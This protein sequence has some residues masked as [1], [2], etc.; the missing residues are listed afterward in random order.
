MSV[1]SNPTSERIRRLQAEVRH[2]I[3]KAQE[4]VREARKQGFAVG[5]ITGGCIVIALD[6]FM[7]L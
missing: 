5:C 2:E 1:Y 3:D 4:A 6:V 7:R